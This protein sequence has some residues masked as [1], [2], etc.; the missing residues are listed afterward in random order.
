MLKFY[1]GSREDGTDTQKKKME[2]NPSK[3]QQR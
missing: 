2:E 1:L 3:L